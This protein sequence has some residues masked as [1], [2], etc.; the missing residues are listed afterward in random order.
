MGVKA[1]PRIAERP[2]RGRADAGRAG[3]GGRARHAARPAH[4]RSTLEGIAERGRGGGHQ[5]ALGDRRRPGRRTPRANRLARAAAPARQEGRGH[6][7]PRPGERA[8]GA[9]ARASVRSPSSFRRSGSSRGSTPRRSRQAIESLHTYA[10][11]CITSPNGARAALRGDGGRRAATRAR[12]PT[13]ASR[14]SAPAPGGARGG[15]NPRRHRARALRRR[16][17]G[18]GADKLELRRASRVLIA[19]AAE[20][21]DLLPEALRKRG[22]K[23]DVVALYLLARPAREAHP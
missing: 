2:D 16:G 17:A 5:A 1:L 22:A 20:A 15:R 9:P 6:P 18:R 12:S 21:R 14:R 19:R 8:R 3:S 11:V 4:G 7:G 23:V 13:R 10:L